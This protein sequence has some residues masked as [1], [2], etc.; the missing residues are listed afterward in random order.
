MNSES[1]NNGVNRVKFES[2]GSELIGNLFCPQGDLENQSFPAVLVV[3]PMATVKEQAAGVFAKKLA[4]LGFITLAFDY[5]RFGESQGQPRHYE[6][7][8]SKSEDIQSAISFLTSLQSTAGVGVLA[9]CA[10]SSYAAPVM[11]SD[12][13][14]GCFATVAAH[15]SLYEFFAENP[16][17][18]DEQKAFL[19]KTSNDARQRYFETGE[20]DCNDMVWPDMSGEEEGE[21]F[22]EIYDYYFARRDAC[23]PNFTNHL[24]VFSYEQ[25]LKSHALDYAK[26]ITKPYLGIVGSEA[27]TRSYTERFVAEKQNG[28]ANLEVIEGASHIQSYDLPDYVNEAASRLT[29]FFTNHLVTPQT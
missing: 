7:P 4:E 2:G 5:R 25:L 29:V 3:G 21:F 9:I 18:T 27:V 23:W 15:F 6:D 8:A 19:L 12:Q 16:M 17:L 10:S 20:V 26:H 24:A 13:R 1:L 14:V 22:R 11:I 28:E